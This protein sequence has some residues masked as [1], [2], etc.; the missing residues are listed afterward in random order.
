MMK[1]NEGSETRVDGSLKTELVEG[2]EVSC[3][4][5]PRNDNTC[6]Q[7]IIDNLGPTGLSISP[8]TDSTKQQ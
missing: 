3:N 1:I 5:T 6:L 2:S 7:K 4:G 8:N